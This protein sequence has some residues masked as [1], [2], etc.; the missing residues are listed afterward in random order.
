MVKFTVVLTD[1]K[2]LAGMTAARMRYNASL[3]KDVMPFHS[4]SEYV[5]FMVQKAAERYAQQLDET[6]PNSPPESPATAEEGPADDL[7]SQL[8]AKIAAELNR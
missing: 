1:P 4:D 6:A 5:Q 8:A 7:E 3:P 2:Q